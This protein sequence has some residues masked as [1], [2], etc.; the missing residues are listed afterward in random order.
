M[1]VLVTYATRYGST[2]E[3]A[4]AVAAAMRE[5]GVETDIRPMPEV[6]TLEGYDAVVMGSALYVGRWHKDARRFLSRQRKALTERPVAIFSLGPTHGPLDE[7]EWQDCRGQ[8]DKELAN[9]PWL[10]PIAVELFGGK[11]DP[12]DLRWPLNKLAGQA[13]ASDIRD[14]DAIRAWASALA[15]KLKAA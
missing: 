9:Y 4:E 15:E 1:S 10:A 12:D 13:P 11:F 14:W 3:V 5:S 7:K 6:G 8:L 2:R